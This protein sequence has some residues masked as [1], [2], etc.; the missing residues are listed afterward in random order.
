[1]IAT[2]PVK[3]SAPRRVRRGVGLVELIVSMAITAS[4]LV[5]VGAAFSATASGIE[6]NDSFFRASQSARVSVNQ[7][8]AEVRKCQSGV[9]DAASL[10]LTTAQ[11]QKRLYAFDAASGE[12]RLSFPDDA[13]PTTHVMARNVTAAAFSTDGKSIAMVVTVKNGKNSVTLSGSAFPRRV[14]TFD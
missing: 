5:A 6:M 10:E 2:H 3:I 4:L 12:L 9:V 13:T 11:G 7:V 1:V 14:M 8:M